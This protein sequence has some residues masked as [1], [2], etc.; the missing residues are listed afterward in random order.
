MLQLW[1]IRY[2]TKDYPNIKKSIETKTCKGKRAIVVAW[3]DSDSSDGDNE[4]E[5]TIDLIEII[6]RRGKKG[7]VDR[8]WVEKREKSKNV[9][10]IREEKD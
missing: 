3:S 2:I 6:Q 8:D 1:T 5:G 9:E 10:R 4:N 7:E